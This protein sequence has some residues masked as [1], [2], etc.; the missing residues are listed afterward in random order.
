MTYLILAF[1]AAI[2]LLGVALAIAVK[3]AAKR[4]KSINDLKDALDVAQIK[5]KLQQEYQRKR[6]EAQQ[7]ADDKKETLHTGDATAD[8]A[9]SIGVLHNTSK[10]RG[11]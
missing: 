2:L 7:N 8:F 11:G 1:I 5:I 3:V 6:E 9:N 4:G 10:N